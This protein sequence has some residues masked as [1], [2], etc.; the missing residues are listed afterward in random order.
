MPTLQL[1]DT[2]GKTVL[3]EATL[4]TREGEWD[5]FNDDEAGQLVSS[6]RRNADY[7][8]PVDHEHDDIRG[9]S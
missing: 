9:K 7:P 5:I 6:I 3:F 2:D 4:G 8:E 1:I